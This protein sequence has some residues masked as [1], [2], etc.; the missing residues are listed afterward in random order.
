MEKEILLK[1]AA[2][3]RDGWE[4]VIEALGIGGLERSGVAGEWRVRDVLAHCNGY[5]RWQTV[6]LSSAFTGETP[7]DEELQGGID[8]P[9]N[10]DFHE[11]AMNAMF[12]AGT[13]DMP[14]SEILRHWREVAA[15]RIAWLL[16]ATQQQL[17]S[18]IG[19]DWGNGTNRIMRL[20]S[21]VPAAANPM[22]AWKLI[23]DQLDHQKMHLEGVKRWM[24]DINQGG[25]AG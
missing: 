21:E 15:M 18:L 9:P 6:Q 23:F 11:D 3:V 17:D 5:D 25:S 12:I 2:D 24:K 19:A 14:T 20:M 10:D 8:Y 16:A 22:P 1:L 13:R 4:A 7:T